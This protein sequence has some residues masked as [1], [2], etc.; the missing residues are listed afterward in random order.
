MKQRYDTIIYRYTGENQFSR[1]YSVI[2]QLVK[3]YP[4][5]S[6]TLTKDTDGDFNPQPLHKNIDIIT[7]KDYS[8]GGK[9]KA[10]AH[11]AY[12]LFIE[13]RKN[14]IP[15]ES[16]TFY[17]N[18]LK[19]TDNDFITI[20]TVYTDSRHMPT[21]K[22]VVNMIYK[23]IPQADVRTLVEK[24]ASSGPSALAY[25]KEVLLPEPRTIKDTRIRHIDR[26]KEIFF[27]DPTILESA[28]LVINAKGGSIEALVTTAWSILIGKITH[29]NRLV[30]S[31]FSMAGSM[32]EYPMIIDTSVDCWQSYAS[33]YDQLLMSPQNA[34]CYIP[35]I[36]GSIGYDYRDKIYVRQNFTGI[37][38]Y[39]KLLARIK[40]NT[41]YQIY[42]GELTDVPLVL[43]YPSL[44][45]SPH[46]EYDY[47]VK[48]FRDINIETLHKNFES[49]MRAMT[50]P[51]IENVFLDKVS[52]LEAESNQK[53]LAT[54]RFTYLR[55]CSLFASIQ[56]DEL[57]SIASRSTTDEYVSEANVQTRGDSV[58]GLHIVANGSLSEYGRNIDGVL[59]PLQLLSIY[60]VFGYE[61]LF[62]DSTAT[63]EYTVISDTAKIITIPNSVLTDV[64]NRHPELHRRLL[65]MEGQEIMRFKTLWM[66]Q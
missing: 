20:F 30:F 16:P 63:T 52:A 35:H 55:E 5:L 13:T 19:L 45:A 12:C 58:R 37:S 66:L 22:D 56:N 41:L 59:V 15:G 28:K 17:T 9:E 50:T 47:D 2:N 27:I 60:G 21:I 64:L 10:F 57:F 46:I 44:T 32:A 31:V 49:I 62:D 36:N 33:V 54:E 18:T 51:K 4:V 25:W 53:R 29:A 8:Q 48:A 61:C 38:D 14:F 34:S 26:Q 23:H 3:R 42:A 43:T 1:V 39:M 24:D 6:M 11:A 7:T 65:E 40:N